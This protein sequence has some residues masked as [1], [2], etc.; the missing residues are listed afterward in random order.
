MIIF[1]NSV[2]IPLRA[3]IL[4]KS[5][6]LGLCFFQPLIFSHFLAGAS[7]SFELLLASRRELGV[8]LFDILP[9]FLDAAE[10]LFDC[11]SLLNTAS[12]K[13]P[14]S[15]TLLFGFR[16]E[17]FGLKTPSS[18]SFLLPPESKLLSASFC[19]LLGLY[20]V[21]LFCCPWSAMIVFVSSI[22]CCKRRRLGSKPS[23]M[24]NSRRLGMKS[25]NVSKSGNEITSM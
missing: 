13:L 22:F 3:Y 7:C 18:P 21:E 23:V 6:L 16:L 15:A 24:S 5:T 2:C 14:L 9:F 4:Q 17:P 20:D 10:S 19:D 11:S 25:Q 12:S 8:W 1:I